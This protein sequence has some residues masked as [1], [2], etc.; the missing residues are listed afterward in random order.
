M[1]FPD[2]LLPAALLWSSN[3]LALLLFALATWMAPWKRLI[4]KGLLNVWLGA[5]VGLML[6]W[7]IKTGIRPGLNFHLL[8]ATLLTLMFGARLALVASGVV[9]LAITLA[10]M[11]GWGSL[12]INWLLTGLLPVSLSYLLYAVVDRKLPNHLFVYIFINAFIGAGL[13][14]VFTGLTTTLLLVLNEAYSSKYLMQNYLPYYLLMGW[15]EAM[16]TGMAVTLMTAF[17]SEWLSTFSD[18]RYLKSK[19]KDGD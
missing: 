1:N 18:V 19:P 15:S 11:A 5:C 3:V 16:L 17:R 10:G 7:S 4:H 6:V 14:V 12:G 13:V 8:G 2:H 9:V